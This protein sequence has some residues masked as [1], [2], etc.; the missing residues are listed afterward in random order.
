MSGNSLASL[1]AWMKGNTRMLGWGLV[2]A[3]ERRKT[4]LIIL[5]EYI[6]RFSQSS[7]L[8][9]IRGE[10]EIVANKRMEVIHDFVMDVPVLSFENA[11]LNDSKA[12]L[13]MAVTGGNQLTMEKESVGWK[14]YKVD[15]IDPLQGP[16]LHLDLLLNEVPGNVNGDGRVRLDLRKSDNFRL[17]FAET[18]HEQLIGGEFFRVLFNKLPDEQRIYTL[19]KIERGTND[20]MRPQSFEL[21]TQANGT[22]ARDPHS[23]VYGDGAV[24][25]F[26]RMERRLGGDFPGAS[27]K[28]L[29]P[30]DQGKDYS[31]TILFDRGRALVAVMLDA[32]GGMVGS[33]DFK[34]DFDGAGELLKAT[35]SS[36]AFVVPQLEFEDPVPLPPDGETIDVK[37][38]V[39][40]MIFPVSSSSPLVVEVLDG[41]VQVSFAS[42]AV[43]GVKYSTPGQVDGVYKARCRINLV[44]EYEVVETVD[45]V[46]LQPTRIDAA[47][48]FEYINTNESPED[49][50]R[51]AFWNLIIFLVTE[52]LLH[53]LYGGVVV[54]RIKY[55]FTALMEFEKPLNET[56]ADI[57]KLNFGQA[58][59]GDEIHA[60]HDVGFFGRIN[61]TSTSFQINPIQPLIKQGGSLQFAT[62]PVVAGVQWKVENLVEGPNSPGTIS[63]S[64]MYQAPPASAIKGRSTR[65]RVTATAPGTGYHSSA[66]VTVLLNELSVNPLI[67]V[68]DVNTSVEL[69]AGS[70]GGAR[71]QWS[72]KNPVAEESGEIRQSEKPGGDHTYHHGPVVAN[73]TYVLDE[74][75]VKNTQT[76]V[77][78]SVHVLAL[79]KAPGATVNILDANIAQGT[80]KLEAIVNGNS[81][82]AEWSLPLEGPGSISQ[83]GLYQAPQTTTERYVLIF[84]VIDGGPFGK[85]EGHL[86][87]PLPLVAFPQALGLPG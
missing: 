62:Q 29:I 61:P 76:N 1:L 25:A 63:A 47:T 78:R 16:K 17:T 23:S 24:L 27:Y 57:I 83:T 68:C 84:A 21:R 79:Q 9:P 15:E 53:A 38:F 19:G 44:A 49:A 31:A 58:I 22:A 37:L 69:A 36:G 42:E 52:L 85:F 55:H 46:L 10:L 73:K 65:V 66:L 82:A 56:I 74:I 86:I 71:L 80:V 59:Q 32:V 87:L 8:P 5:Q 3:L 70:L 6:K 54:E 43:A 75:E 18:D 81:M 77:S 4:N 30:D 60:P 39:E 64:G 34:F 35:L 7:S 51:N 67:Q 2:V 13:T 20:L 72:I 12:M 50:A 41:K 40:E 14:V 28:Y 45:G 11:D 33:R 48:Q 26:V